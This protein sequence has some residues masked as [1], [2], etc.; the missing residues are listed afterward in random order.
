MRAVGGGESVGADKSGG[1]GGFREFRD[2]R[3][4]GR[5]L[6]DLAGDEGQ[7]GIVEVGAEV[8]D[9]GLEF[10]EVCIRRFLIAFP[11][12]PEHALEGA[13]PQGGLGAFAR[14]PIQLGLAEP[15]VDFRAAAGVDDE[16]DRQVLVLF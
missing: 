14:A 8:A 3:V 1:V 12:M 6:V 4:D 5:A 7:V 13:A 11:L 16:A 10:F 2:L 9:E 15:F